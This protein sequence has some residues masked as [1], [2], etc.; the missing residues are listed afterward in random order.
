[1][2]GDDRAVSEVIAFVLVFTIIIFSVAVLS[3]VGFSS[4]ESYKDGEQT[5]NADRAM[6][7]LAD[8]LN[9]VAR[10]AGIERRSGELALREGTIGT[11]SGATVSVEMDT[12]NGEEELFDDSLGRFTYT[13]DGDTIAYEGGTVFRIGDGGSVAR[14]A[15][16][17]T[18]RDGTAVLTLV[19]IE[20]TDRTV[21]SADSREVRLV[22]NRTEVRTESVETLTVT[23][24]DDRTATAWARA[25]ED[26]GWEADVDGSTATVEPDG[27]CELEQATVRI[28]HVDVGY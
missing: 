4:M 20:P 10:Q 22:E 19:V 3:T 9:D 21:Q 5:A 17:A 18:C 2:I 28:V 27:D 16:M 1:M 11:D 26:R 23:V 8:N 7:A 12:G 13:G 15:P 14:A 6:V 24:D 25:L